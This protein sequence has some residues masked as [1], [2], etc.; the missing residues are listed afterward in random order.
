[1]VWRSLKGSGY[2][3]YCQRQRFARSFLRLW[4]IRVK[5]RVFRRSAAVDEII[6][7]WKSVVFHR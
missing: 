7:L 3:G 4:I 6:H 5:D 1:M 2:L